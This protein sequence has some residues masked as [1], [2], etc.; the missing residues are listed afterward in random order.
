MVRKEKDDFLTPQRFAPANCLIRAT[1][2][3]II[4]IKTKN[5]NIGTRL[6]TIAGIKNV[7]R[8]TTIKTVSDILAIEFFI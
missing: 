5:P 3:M 7:E 6:P 2:K 8:K 4:A 1:I